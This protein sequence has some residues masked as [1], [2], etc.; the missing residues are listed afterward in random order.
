MRIRGK[1]IHSVEHP[2]HYA[3][4]GCRKAF[5]QRGSRHPSQ[6]WIAEQDRS[7]P[8]PECKTAMVSLGRDFEAPP[9]R[10]RNQWLKIEL[11]HSFGFIFEVPID[12]AG[13]RGPRPCELGEATGFLTAHGFDA[14]EVRRRLREIRKRRNGIAPDASDGGMLSVLSHRTHPD[15]RVM[16]WKRSEQ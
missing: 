15:R 2:Q 8:C 7:F 5:K 11:L 10:S 12:D 6:F 13:A 1:E 3:C 16:N 14:A 4:F 9:K